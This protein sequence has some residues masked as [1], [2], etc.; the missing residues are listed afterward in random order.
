MPEAILPVM[1]ETGSAGISRGRIKFRMT[2]ATSVMRNHRIFL[3][4]YFR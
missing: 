1:A 4:K 3:P 2:A